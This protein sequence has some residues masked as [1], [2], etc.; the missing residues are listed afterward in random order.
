MRSRVLLEAAIALVIGGAA[1]SG[2]QET[3]QRSEEGPIA[4][5]RPAPAFS[6]PSASGG[7]VS[8]SDYAGKPVLLYFSMGPG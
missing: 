2:Q 5:G 3:P 8:L 7:T 4:V 6:L 1:C